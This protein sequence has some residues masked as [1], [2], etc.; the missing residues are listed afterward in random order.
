MR[1]AGGETPTLFPFYDEFPAGVD[2]AREPGT[3]VVT[4]GDLAEGGTDDSHWDVARSVWRADEIRF[5]PVRVERFRVEVGPE[6]ERR[7]PE[8]RGNPFLS[9]AGR[10]G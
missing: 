8:V 5:E 3:I 9:C 6:A 10:I 2:C 7:W 1:L 4:L